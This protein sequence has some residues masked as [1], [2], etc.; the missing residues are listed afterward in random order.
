MS[1]GGEVIADVLVRGISGIVFG[2]GLSSCTGDD[3][4]DGDA[5]MAGSLELQA[6]ATGKDKN[7]TAISAFWKC[8]RIS[9]IS[10]A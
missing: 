9:P 8:L 3:S 7:I 10:V 2:D 5:G 4:G 6:L 1:G